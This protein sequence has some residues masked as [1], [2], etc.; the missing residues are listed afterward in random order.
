MSSHDDNQRNPRI[1]GTQPA[2]P[3]TQQVIEELAR[4]ASRSP[5]ARSR[6][7]SGTATAR[8]PRDPAKDP[9]TSSGHRSTGVSSPTRTTRRRSGRCAPSSNG[10][11]PGG[12]SPP[13]S[14]PTTAG[15]CTPTSSRRSPP[16]G[17]CGRDTFATPTPTSS[18]PSPS[19]SAPTSS[20]SASPLPIV[21]VAGTNM[22]QHRPHQTWSYLICHHFCWPMQARDTGPGMLQ[23][24][25]DDP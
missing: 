10:P 4:S 21:D 14:S 3:A 8:R 22:S 19:T 12:T 2:N 23:P 7:T 13:T 15:G 6:K 9:R 18:T 20:K 11:S 17:D 24:S 25:S 5:T 16:G 1:E